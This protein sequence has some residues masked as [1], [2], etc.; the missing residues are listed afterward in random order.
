[1]GAEE[2]GKIPWK[3]PGETGEIFQLP[4]K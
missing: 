4:G 1:M 3:I 2:T